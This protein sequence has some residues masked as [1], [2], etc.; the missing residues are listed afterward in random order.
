MFNCKSPEQDRYFSVPT[1]EVS[2]GM[3]SLVTKT[4]SNLYFILSTLKYILSPYNVHNHSFYDEKLLTELSTF[5]RYTLTMTLIPN[6]EDPI[7]TETLALSDSLRLACHSLLD[8]LESTTKSS[9]SQ[10]IDV[11]T[12]TQRARHVKRLEAMLTQLKAL[13]RAAFVATR[14]SKE[15]TARMRSEVDRLNLG[16][17]NLWYES[18]HLR[19]EIVGCKDFP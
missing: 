15:R 2:S 8:L 4:H 13:H 1:W 11:E 12:R 7:I 19:G 5:P 9:T 16:L 3:L 10:E 17:Q 6:T 18:R 14:E